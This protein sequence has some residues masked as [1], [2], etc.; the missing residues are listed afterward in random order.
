MYAVGSVKNLQQLQ[1]TW[2][3]KYCIQ[4]VII[5]DELQ[6][7]ILPIATIFLGQSFILAWVM[8]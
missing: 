1:N 7:T 8:F 6:V 2:I 4:A 5:R 3:L